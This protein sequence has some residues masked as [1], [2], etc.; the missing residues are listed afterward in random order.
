M[1]G[2]NDRDR[3]SCWG[4]NVAT[5]ANVSGIST[6]GVRQNVIV[7]MAATTV[8]IATAAVLWQTSNTRSEPYEYKSDVSDAIHLMIPWYY[9]KRTF[10]FANGFSCT[11]YLARMP[12][13][14]LP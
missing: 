2:H 9:F 3:S 4:H 12:P 7:V 11:S 5:G 14:C 10:V 8:R 13:R 6:T 1:C